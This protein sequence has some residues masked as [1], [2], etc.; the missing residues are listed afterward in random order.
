MISVFFLTLW[1]VEGSYEKID[2][3]HHQVTVPESVRPPLRVY[4]QLFLTSLLVGF[5]L[6]L[7]VHVGIQILARQNYSRQTSFTRCNLPEFGASAGKG[8]KLHEETEESGTDYEDMLYSHHKTTFHHRMANGTIVSETKRISRTQS[9]QGMS[10]PEIKRIPRT[11][12]DRGMS[13]PGT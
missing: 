6:G 13:L 8:R 3:A 2:D 9:D 10:L 5:A 11:H 7:G 12:S 4:M 1:V